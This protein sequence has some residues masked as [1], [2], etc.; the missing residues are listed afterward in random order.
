MYNFQLKVETRSK[1]DKHFII[2][3]KTMFAE[4]VNSYTRQCFTTNFTIVSN[5]SLST[6]GQQPNLNANVVC[7]QLVITSVPQLPEYCAYQLKPPDRLILIT[8]Y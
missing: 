1:L 2:K 5:G 4:N 3:T 8:V 7:I 6:V